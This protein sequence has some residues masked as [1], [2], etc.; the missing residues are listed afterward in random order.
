MKQ[1][2]SWSLPW[3]IPTHLRTPPRRQLGRQKSRRTLNPRSKQQ[4]GQVQPLPEWPIH[5]KLSQL[6][7][8]VFVSASR[9]RQ[10]TPL[11][12]AKMI[13]PSQLD[14]KGW[15]SLKVYHWSM[16]TQTAQN[17]RCG[18]S[19][20]TVKLYFRLTTWQ[21]LILFIFK[22]YLHGVTRYL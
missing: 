12:L 19:A 22:K 5:P 3:L 10:E 18:T 11:Y 15:R 17:W 14:S 16:K 21:V 2:M 7:H 13:W 6:W 20:L 4:R 8:Q 9:W 1:P